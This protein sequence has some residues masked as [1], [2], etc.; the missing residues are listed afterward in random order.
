MGRPS[1]NERSG[2]RAPSR[3]LAAPGRRTVDCRRTDAAA[4]SPDAGPVTATVDR[5]AGRERAC[6]RTGEVALIDEAAAGRDRDERLA[7]GAHQVCGALDTAS[8]LVVGRR[9][10]EEP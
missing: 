4:A 6:E 1:R 5:R 7:G 3:T 9:A 8:P 2:R 10:A